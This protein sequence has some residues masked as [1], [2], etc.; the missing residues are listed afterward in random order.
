HYW[1]SLIW[2]ADIHELATSERSLD[3]RI[4][5]ERAHSTGT[6]EFVHLALR[7][8]S[9]VFQ[10]PLPP[11]MEASSRDAS[12]ME[13]VFSDCMNCLVG[14][15]SDPGPHSILLRLRPHRSWQLAYLLRLAVTPGSVEWSW[16]RLPRGLS[17][18]YF[19]FRVLRPVAL[20]F[21]KLA[22]FVRGKA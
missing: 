9:A 3:W 18:G 6:L 8:S 15:A 10:H 1:S 13:S 7:M 16:M 5:R 20:A 22:A 11:E 21:R 12:S 14:N 17:F 2:I 19:A 4:L